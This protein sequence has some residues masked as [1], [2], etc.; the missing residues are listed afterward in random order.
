MRYE[1]ARQIINRTFNKFLVNYSKQP[2]DLLNGLKDKK[3]QRAVESALKY[4]QRIE[5]ST[6]MYYTNVDFNDYFSIS[7]QLYYVSDRWRCTGRLLF[8]KRVCEE[9]NQ[10]QISK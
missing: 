2:D 3:F 7:S 1:K 8:I 6:E 9:I 5:Q 4:H 10:N